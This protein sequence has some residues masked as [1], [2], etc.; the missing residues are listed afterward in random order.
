MNRKAYFVDNETYELY[1]LS[2][3]KRK[4]LEKNHPNWLQYDCV[5]NKKDLEEVFS[6]FK[7]HGKFL[8]HSKFQNVFVGLTV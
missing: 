5:K 7:N 4:K 1:E 3:S 8:A 2:V 6:Y